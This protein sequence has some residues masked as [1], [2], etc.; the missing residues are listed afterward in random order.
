MAGIRVK[1]NKREVLFY[2]GFLVMMIRKFG[3]LI[4][5]IDIPFLSSGAIVLVGIL[6][7]LNTFLQG[8]NLIEVCVCIFG[9]YSYYITRDVT[10]MFYILTILASKNIDKNKIV[11]FYFVIQSVVLVPC[12]VLYSLFY[13]VGS[14]YAV[15]SLIDGRVRHFF[16]FT[17][18][19]NFAVQVV[20]WVL[21]YIYLKFEKI[22]DLYKYILL[23][24][25]SIFLLVLPN[26]QTAALALIIFAQLL[27]FLR[28][29][30]IIWKYF[31]K[32]GLVMI[33][34][35]S[36]YITWTFYTGR[37]NSFT[38]MISGTFESRFIGAASALKLYPINLFG[39]AL[40]D[41]GKLIQVD[42]KWITLWADLAY[43]R[44]FIEFGVISGSVF[45]WLLFKTIYMDIK[46]RD[47]KEL[48]FLS[49]VCIYAVSEWAAFSIPTVFPLLFTGKA[50]KKSKS[51]IRI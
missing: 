10:I 48:L 24:V 37:T 31:V 13:F 25:T 47:Y 15:V 22:S 33:F 40:P 32:I 36:I 23:F 1:L 9:I 49:I 44:I 41:L 28:Y 45:L 42:G 4:S 26:S 43:V 50:I 35:I 3:L 14:P 8:T 27:I 30:R 21:A 17:H 51:S 16:L 5:V 29:G 20:F 18:P 7:L 19:N 6:F 38:S 39:Q 34:L 2:C 11:K 46:N 12:I